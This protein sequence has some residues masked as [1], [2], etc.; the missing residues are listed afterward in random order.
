[1]GRVPSHGEAALPFGI[2]HLKY[3]M[4]AHFAPLQ[5]RFKIAVPFFIASGICCTSRW[6]VVR[7]FDVRW[8]FC[9]LGRVGLFGRKRKGVV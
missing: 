8:V 9:K 7:G 1:M 4:T 5:T 2:L 3:L 6:L